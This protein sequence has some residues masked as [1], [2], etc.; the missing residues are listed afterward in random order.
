MSNHVY[1]GVTI[2]GTSNQSFSHAIEVAIE[3]AK[4]TLRELRWFELRE[5]RGAIRDGKVEYQVT[6][7]VFFRLMDDD[8]AT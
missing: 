1:K 3:R 5:Q 8:S 7:E 6:L 4:Q 2:A